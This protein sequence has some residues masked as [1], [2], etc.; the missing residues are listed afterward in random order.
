H[1]LSQPILDLE[2]SVDGPVHLFGRDHPSGRYLRETGDDTQRRAHALDAA[3]E[4]PATSESMSQIQG[5][6]DGAA[7]GERS[8]RLEQLLAR[9]DVKAGYARE[10]GGE[11]L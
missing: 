9:H 11:A 6:D 8:P 7:L 4:H 10:I 1:R 2:D 5:V 3:G